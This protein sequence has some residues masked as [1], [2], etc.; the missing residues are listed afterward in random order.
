[1]AT[2]E[3]DLVGGQTSFPLSE[4]VEHEAASPHVEHEAASPHVEQEAAAPPV[5]I[6][7]VGASAGGFEAFK[8]LLEALPP[9]P[10][11]ALIFVQ[12]LDPGHESMLQTL[13]GRLTRMK[14]LQVQENVRVEPNHVY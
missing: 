6:V 14:V 1:M 3:S 10:G 11:I 2:D 4:N 7:G 12:H 9:N 8:E 13:L 5:M